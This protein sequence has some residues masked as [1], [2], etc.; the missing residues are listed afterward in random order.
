MKPAVT[1]VRVLLGLAFLLFGLMAVGIIPMPPPPEL[2][3]HAAEFNSALGG[4]GYFKGIGAVEIIGGLLLLIS[5]RLAPIGLLFIGPVVVNIVFYHAFIQPA[6]SGPA[7]VVSV[8]S[9]F[10]LWYYRK[11]FAGLARAE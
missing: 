3:G 6:G 5:G 11:A 7:V 8:L 9:L 4:S 2:K 10:L 1:I